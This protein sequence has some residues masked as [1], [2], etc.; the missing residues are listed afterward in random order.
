VR[1]PHQREAAGAGLV[2][3]EGV[4]AFAQVGQRLEQLPQLRPTRANEPRLPAAVLGHSDCDGVFVNVQAD[5]Y[6]VI[7]FHGLPPGSNA[8]IA[9]RH[10][11]CGA[12]HFG[13]QSTIRQEVDLPV[14]FRGPSRRRAG[15]GHV[16]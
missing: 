11:A 13:A 15:Q 8:D 7:V 1:L 14:L 5:E 3:D 2:G 16:V 9:L 12:T 4:R 6:G 10:S